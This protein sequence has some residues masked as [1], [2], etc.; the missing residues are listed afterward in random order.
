MRVDPWYALKS[1]REVPSE[2]VFP[3]KIRLK[4]FLFTIMIPNGAACHLCTQN[5]SVVTYP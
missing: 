3:L 5:L 2:I 4:R 1:A